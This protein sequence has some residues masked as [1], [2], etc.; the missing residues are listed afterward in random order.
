MPKGYFIGEV[1]IT[2]PDGY[3]A[4]R[5]RVVPT[6]QKYGGRFLT[7]GGDPKLIEGANEAK[8][9]VI[10]EFDSPEQAATW[11]NS[12]EYQEILP[13]RMAN[14]TARAHILTGI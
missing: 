14:S 4:Y 6:V 13:I 1:D 9:I 12:P 7:R 3:E 8:R 11:Y 10:L 5:A 2:N